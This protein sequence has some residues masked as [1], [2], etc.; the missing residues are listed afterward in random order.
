MNKLLANKD[1][2]LR[3][4]F[5]IAYLIPIAGM[6]FVI[7]KDGMQT[8]L[9]TTQIDT[10]AIIV[11]MSMVHAPTIAAMIVAYRDEGFEGI[12]DLFRQLK[13]W[14]FRS[15]WYLIAL[16]TFPLSI[17]AVLYSMIFYLKASLQYCL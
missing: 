12:K 17:L 13:Y 4:F 11:I 3:N 15:K 10:N 6:L 9:V 14:R 5:V 2:S 8:N 7:L 16:L 1:T